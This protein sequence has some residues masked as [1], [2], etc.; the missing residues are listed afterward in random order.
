MAARGESRGGLSEQDPLSSFSFHFH[1]PRMCIYQE[2]KSMFCSRASTVGRIFPILS[3]PPN[4]LH[5][6]DNRCLFRVNTCRFWSHCHIYL[7]FHASIIPPFHSAIV[8]AVIDF[9][10]VVRGFRSSSS[11]KHMPIIRV[12]GRPVTG[13]GLG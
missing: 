1:F 9:V 11:T 3:N 10:F 6:N 5:M 2:S 13:L 8:M 12:R 4:Y 7:K